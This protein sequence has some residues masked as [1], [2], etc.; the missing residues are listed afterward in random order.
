MVNQAVEVQFLRMSTPRGKEAHWT[1]FN[2][3]VCQVL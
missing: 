3:L 1:E 2:E